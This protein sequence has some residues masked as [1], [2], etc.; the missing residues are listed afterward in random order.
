MV[1]TYQMGLPNGIWCTDDN[2]LKEG[3]LDFFKNLFCSLSH[4][5][6]VAKS[7]RNLDVPHLLEAARKSLTCSVTR[8]EVSNALNNM[9]TYTKLSGQMVFRVSSL[10][11]IG[12][13][14]RR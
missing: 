8:D 1:S 11:T 4:Q 7:T 13:Y 10:N 14:S 5:N 6:T 12:T 3:V 2:L 9:H